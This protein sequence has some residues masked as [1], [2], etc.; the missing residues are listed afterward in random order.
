MRIAYVLLAALTAGLLCSCMSQAVMS[1]GKIHDEPTVTAARQS[2]LVELFTSEGCSS[3]P[4]ADKELEFLADQQPVTNA[5]IITLAFHVDYWDN[6]NWKDQFSSSV[7]TQR[8]ELYARQLKLDSPYTPQIVVGGRR[9][10]V[11]TDFNK[12]LIAIMEAARGPSGVIGT[13][14]ADGKVRISISALP[15]HGPA[16]VY[17][18]AAEDNLSSKIGGGENA[19]SR[20]RH[21]AVVRELRPVGLVA[22]SNTAFSTE[23]ELPYSSDWKPKNVKYVAFV[24]DNSDRRILA[25]GRITP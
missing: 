3:C 25:V 22:G 7:F 23:T 21:M 12:A 18:A 4:P 16:T 6:A 14:V 2:V 5:D 9:D 10:L 11:G 13:A 1:E 24:Q 19:G 20:F 8:Q 15:E 17:I